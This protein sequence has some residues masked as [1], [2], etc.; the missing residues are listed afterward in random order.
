MCILDK[1]SILKVNTVTKYLGV[2]ILK[3]DKYTKMYISM[4]DSCDVLDISEDSLSRMSTKEI[5]DVSLRLSKGAELSFHVDEN[6][7]KAIESL[8]EIIKTITSNRIKEGNVKYHTKHKARHFVL[9]SKGKGKDVANSV[10]GPFSFVSD[11]KEFMKSISN[12]DKCIVHDGVVYTTSKH[13]YIDV[14][15]DMVYIEVTSKLSHIKY[16]PKYAV[17]RVGEF[18]DMK[19]SRSCILHVNYKL[20]DITDGGLLHGNELVHITK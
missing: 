9:M 13:K 1:I 19:S 14:D 15:G 2:S 4:K 3:T 8:P 17:V 20:M 11:A 12:I 7:I 10:Y 6:D 5:H 18:N 16:E